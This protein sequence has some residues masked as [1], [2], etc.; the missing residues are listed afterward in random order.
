[1]LRYLRDNFPRFFREQFAKLK[2]LN[3]CR[4]STSTTVLLS[5][6]S[7]HTN[8]LIFF[9]GYQ[10][11]STCSNLLLW[12][13]FVL[14]TLFFPPPLILLFPLT[15]VAVEPFHISIEHVS[16]VSE[17]QE[18]RQETNIMNDGIKKKLV[19]GWVDVVDDV[20]KLSSP[21][22]LDTRHKGWKKMKNIST[23]SF[24]VSSPFFCSSKLF[25]AALNQQLFT[26]RADWY[27]N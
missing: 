11:T 27:E 2:L 7:L 4:M 18:E 14:L 10:K 9:W 24:R 20:P 12:L 5:S 8:I 13:S 6:T 25:Q 21:H 19:G 1:M 16:L 22:S 17:V 26:P 15:D 23:L 3:L